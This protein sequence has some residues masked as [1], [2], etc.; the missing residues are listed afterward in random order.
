MASVSHSFGIYAVV[1]TQ[2]LIPASNCFSFLFLFNGFCSFIHFLI[3][4]LTSCDVS[5]NRGAVPFSHQ[6]VS[7]QSSHKTIINGQHKS[8]NMLQ[9]THSASDFSSTLSTS[10]SSAL[11]TLSSSS[12]IPFATPSAA[13]FTS[14]ITSLTL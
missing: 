11:S 12:F 4:I 3:F 2:H 8:I 7:P 1:L 5:D 10:I 9:N 13:I 6:L 14:Q